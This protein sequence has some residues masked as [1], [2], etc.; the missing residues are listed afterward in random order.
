MP[1]RKI[2]S[3]VKPRL[4]G[5]DVRCVRGTPTQVDEV[6]WSAAERFPWR[7][8]GT[9]DYPVLLINDQTH[10]LLA[11]VIGREDRKG[12]ALRA[13]RSGQW[14]EQLRRIGRL[15]ARQSAYPVLGQK[16]EFLLLRT[17]LARPCPLRLPAMSL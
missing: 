3:Q 2:P 13:S 1:G 5:V 17:S 6:W 4:H 11:R 16:Q 15:S 12:I 7:L 9:T 10:T 14:I 8:R